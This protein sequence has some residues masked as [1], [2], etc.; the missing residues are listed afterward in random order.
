M[1][2]ILIIDDQI[3]PMSNPLI[4]GLSREGFSAQ[5]KSFTEGIMFKIDELKKFGLIIS[6]IR[7]EKGDDNYSILCF[8]RKN[9]LQTPIILRTNYPKYELDH[10]LVKDFIDKNGSGLFY[11]SKEESVGEAISK[12]LKTIDQGLSDKSM[13]EKINSILSNLS[14]PDISV[15]VLKILTLCSCKDEKNFQKADKL[16]RNLKEKLIKQPEKDHKNQGSFDN[17]YADAEE[18]FKRLQECPDL[19]DPADNGQLKDGKHPYL[20]HLEK[21]RNKLLDLNK[22]N[23]V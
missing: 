11:L 23:P 22:I 18:Y 5:I 12:I 17:L 13:I 8:A 6:D 4:I 9:K 14:I 10:V 1:R 19:F 15:L 21:M 7:D 16:F 3:D 2:N 20:Y